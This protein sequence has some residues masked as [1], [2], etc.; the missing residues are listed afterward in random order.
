M[1]LRKFGTDIREKQWAILNV[2]LYRIPIAWYI[3]Q[4]RPEIY[5]LTTNSQS[6]NSY[7]VFNMERS[8]TIQFLRHSISW[9][10]FHH[11]NPLHV[12]HIQLK[13][14][15]YPILCHQL[16]CTYRLRLI[17]HATRLKNS[18]CLFL[19]FVTKIRY[20][21]ALPLISFTSHLLCHLCSLSFV[22]SCISTFYG[23]RLIRVDV[24]KGSFM[25]L[26]DSFRLSIR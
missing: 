9:T 20:I 21:R 6:I 26:L 8:V 2:E 13:L 4:I 11:Y 22:N 25:L 10:C 1:F 16:R 14:C 23:L 18:G 17:F 24:Y 5:Y 15:A 12:H 19:Y 3:R 7:T